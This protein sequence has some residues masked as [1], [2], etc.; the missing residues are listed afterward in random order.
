MDKKLHTM[1]KECFP[2]VIYISYGINKYTVKEVY[3]N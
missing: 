1:L 3:L 2:I